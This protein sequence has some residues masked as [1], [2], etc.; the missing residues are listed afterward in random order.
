MSWWHRQAIRESRYPQI[1]P[2]ARLLGHHNSMARDVP[3]Q[4]FQSI[5][6]VLLAVAGALLFQVRFF[7]L[8]NQER[9]KKVDPFLRLVMIAVITA[10]LFTCLEAMREGWGP[11][12]AALVT[13]GL[14]LSLLPILLRVLPPLTRRR[15][16]VLSR[17]SPRRREAQPVLAR[18]APFW[19]TCP[20]RAR[21]DA[22]R[23]RLWRPGNVCSGVP[24]FPVWGRSR[25]RGVAQGE[26]QGR[27]PVRQHYWP[28]QRIM[29]G[30]HAFRGGRGVETAC[31]AG[32]FGLVRYATRHLSG[33]AAARA[34]RR[35]L[36]AFSI[37]LTLAPPSGVR[38][39]SRTC[40]LRRRRCSSVSGGLR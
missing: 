3:V 34:A 28:G 40:S 4:Y 7:E 16:T 14:A 33:P 6:T 12:A 37:A 11:L 15:A 35:C 9:T 26:G 39:R 36:L 31:A 22:P 38:R 17:P 13:T 10:T 19:I 21:A 27:S 18:P 20:P 5:I 1:R 24:V 25:P 8:T 2:S 29:L 30:R 32:G 23:A